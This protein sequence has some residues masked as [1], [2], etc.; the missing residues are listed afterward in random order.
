MQAQTLD[1]LDYLDLSSYLEAILRTEGGEVVFEL[2]F[3][4]FRALQRCSLSAGRILAR[5]AFQGA[6]CVLCHL[7]RRWLQIF[8][9]SHRPPGLGDFQHSIGERSHARTP[10]GPTHPGFS[11]VFRSYLAPFIR[12]GHG[13]ED[14]LQDEDVVL[15][16][17]ERARPPATLRGK[18]VSITDVEKEW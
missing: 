10:L 8:F 7:L 11:E 3:D 6:Q 9:F 17:E 15:G 4:T 18:L 14:P 5:E 2:Q 1:I 12:L 16:R 13:G